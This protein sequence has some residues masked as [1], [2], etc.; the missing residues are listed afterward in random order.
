KGSK[1]HIKMKSRGH[2]KTDTYKKTSTNTDPNLDANLTTWNVVELESKPLRLGSDACIY[3]GEFGKRAVAVKRIQCRNDEELQK[4]LLLKDSKVGHRNLLRYHSVQKDIEGV[5]VALDIYDQT[6]EQQI[7]NLEL[8][9]FTSL[10]ILKQITEGLAYLHQNKMVHGNLN[11]GNILLCWYSERTVCAKIADVG[12]GYPEPSKM[13][14][15][16]FLEELDRWKSPE[17]KTFKKMS[18]ACDI[19]SLGCIFYYV[20]SG[21]KHLFSTADP[22]CKGFWKEDDSN[23]PKTRLVLGN[24]QLIKE[25]TAE[26]TKKRPKVD[27]ILPHHIFWPKE[28]TLHF[29][30]HVANIIATVKS[31]EIKAIVKEIEKHYDQVVSPRTRHYLGTWLTFMQMDVGEYRA[32]YIKTA[33]KH[34]KNKISGFFN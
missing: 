23:E 9:A 27:D 25:M 34:Y 12:I 24:L 28:K 20:L 18:G 17:L 2:L 29:L 13:S 8:D 7:T 16:K 10:W 1:M 19:F 6:L 5:Y 14:S 4:A 33:G 3:K 30:V 15:A 21:G 11:P 26:T 32:S 31:P 22:N